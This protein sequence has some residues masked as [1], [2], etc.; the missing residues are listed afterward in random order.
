MKTLS[1]PLEEGL[2]AR[3]R[4]LAT[5]LRPGTV[6]SY[7]QTVRLFMIYLRANFPELRRPDQLRRGW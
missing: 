3:V 2:R 1:H 7:N 5:T 4:L 6:H